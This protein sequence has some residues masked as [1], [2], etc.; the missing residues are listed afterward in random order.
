MTRDDGNNIGSGVVGEY[1]TRLQEAIVAL[2]VIPP[3]S[4]YESPVINRDQVLGAIAFVGLLSS[5]DGELRES[6]GEII[7]HIEHIRYLFNE[8]EKTASRFCNLMKDAIPN[9]VEGDAS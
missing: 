7:P 3:N 6:M 8:M 1:L 9:S 5:I 2:P 4:Y